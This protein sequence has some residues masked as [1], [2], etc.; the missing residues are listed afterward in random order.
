MVLS[1]ENMT[2]SAIRKKSIYSPIV[3]AVEQAC[4]ILI[5]MGEGDTSRMRLTDI[6]KEVEIPKSKGHTILNT[7][8][9]SELVE[10]N[11]IT[12]TYSLGPALVFLSR[13]FLDNLNLT[14]VVSPIINSIAHGTNGTAI[15]GLI[16]ERKLF[17]IAQQEGG[18]NIGFT[19]RLGYRFHL[20][21]GAHGKAILAFM[22]DAE[23]EKLLAGKVYCHGDPARLDMERLRKELEECRVNGYAR[24]IGE[25]NPG[26]NAVSAPVFGSKDE[27]IG[28]IELFGSFSGNLIEEYGLKVAEAARKVSYKLGTRPNSR[29]SSSNK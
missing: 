10:K 15:F 3:P 21:L 1:T 29:K 25:I 28:C 20:T 9:N 8:V 17:V 12:K 27:L 16:R 26:L 19:V 18:K 24:D 4:R 23:R 2:T 6:C 22:P 13:R 5:C 14:D 11:P 7:L